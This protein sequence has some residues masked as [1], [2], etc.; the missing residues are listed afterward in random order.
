M[1]KRIKRHIR[2]LSV[3]FNTYGNGSVND[4][5]KL[6]CN[7][8]LLFEAVS[9]RILPS[10]GKKQRTYPEYEIS[11]SVG[12]LAAVWKKISKES[13]NKYPNAIDASAILLTL[14]YAIDDY[15]DEQ[16][17]DK[18][19][20]KLHK[21]FIAQKSLKP[22]CLM[23][24]LERINISN[25]NGKNTY[26]H[27]ISV[28][29][30]NYKNLSS[31]EKINIID[32]V[33]S[34]IVKCIEHCLINESST[35]QK[36]DI[37]DFNDGFNEKLLFTG[38][39]AK[40]ISYTFS[41]SRQ[42]NKSQIESESLIIIVISMIGQF[43]DDLWDIHQDITKNS[44]SNLF[45]TYSKENHPS[46]YFAIKNFVEMNKPR[47]DFIP[48][49]IVM[50]ISPKSLTE[51]GDVMAD[52]LIKLVKNTIGENHEIINFIEDQRREFFSLFKII[53]IRPTKQM[54]TKYQ[55]KD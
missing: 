31:Q 44:R 19:K 18:E 35:T 10:K 30:N 22:N 47:I 42:A 17:N 32:E 39:F 6:R 34:F 7:S 37:L 43:H 14:V 33:D 9:L 21:E 3:I 36:K 49:K 52:N 38:T 25:I 54:D 40:L 28:I 4:Y 8:K 46:E 27:F 24:I 16:I 11:Y 48:A 41:Y 5:L 26:N 1:L 2:Y 12:I 20:L 50:E 23:D 51:Y 55:V 29:N 53:K 45:L 15:L 13:I